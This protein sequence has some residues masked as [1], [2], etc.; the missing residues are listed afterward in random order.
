MTLETLLESTA[1]E[2]E[3][4]YGF[5]LPSKIKRFFIPSL[6]KRAYEVGWRAGLEHQG[7]TSSLSAT[8][9]GDLI[10]GIPENATFAGK[11]G[12]G[13]IMIGSPHRNWLYEMFCKIRGL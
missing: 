13:I 5:I 3:R 12:P 6:V 8:G 4:T 1:E 7:V 2:V 10:V 11:K 9:E